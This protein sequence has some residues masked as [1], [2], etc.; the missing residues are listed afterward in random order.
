MSYMGEPPLS[1]PTWPDL[2]AWRDKALAAEA[3]LAAWQITANERAVEILALKTELDLARHL[4]AELSL[5]P[6]K[7]PAPPA[8]AAPDP[9][10]LADAAVARI[11]RKSI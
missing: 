3:D 11:A 10:A 4:I 6:A 1:P 8:P 7:P 9:R 2:K 5:A